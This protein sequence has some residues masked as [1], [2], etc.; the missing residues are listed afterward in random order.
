MESI[1]PYDRYR[2][3]IDT[4]YAKASSVSWA[5]QFEAAPTELCT[6]RD[7]ATSIL[8][9]MPAV[10]WTHAYKD[11]ESNWAWRPKHLPASIETGEVALERRIIEHALGAGLAN[12]T[13]QM[14]T[15]S[16]LT[17]PHSHKR[18]SIDLVHQCGDGR[19]ELIELK[20]T[21]DDPA[22][23][24]FEVLFYGMAYLRAREQMKLPVDDLHRIMNARRIDLV[25]LAPRP[26]YSFKMRHTDL[27]VSYA[28]GRLNHVLNETLAIIRD[29]LGLA[30]LDA[31]TF[32]FKIFDDEADLLAAVAAGRDA[33]RAYA[34]GSE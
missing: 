30:G 26:W 11:V 18:R 4:L 34:R 24:A 6:P 25:V 13:F 10:A 9:A 17:G 5:R 19:F 22:H 1:D 14:P 8:E 31:L 23:A 12:W 20:W 29:N 33:G 21:S 28:L 16:G 32:G 27:T 7:L 2:Q 3:V 15:M